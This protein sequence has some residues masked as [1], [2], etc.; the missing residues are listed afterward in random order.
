MTKQ[1]VLIVWVEERLNSNWTVDYSIETYFAE[2]AKSCEQHY[3]SQ[4]NQS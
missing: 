2:S 1:V 4:V 3:F